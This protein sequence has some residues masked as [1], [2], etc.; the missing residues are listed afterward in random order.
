ME[1]EFERQE[2]FEGESLI[3]DII[4]LVVKCML[5]EGNGEWNEERGFWFGLG[6]A[7]GVAWRGLESRCWLE[8]GL[9]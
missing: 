9:E 2:G 6:L 5:K 4:N 3:S 1:C 7:V 8:L